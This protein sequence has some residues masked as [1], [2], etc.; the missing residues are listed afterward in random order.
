MLPRHPH[1]QHSR[2]ADPPGFAVGLQGLGFQAEDLAN[3]L[4]DV[5]KPHHAGIVLDHFAK[6]LFG[7]RHRDLLRHRL[8]GGLQAA[9]G[10]GKFAGVSRQPGR[11]KALHVARHFNPQ[12]QR[13]MFDDPQARGKIGRF[14]AADHPARQA[15]DQFR[16]E[17]VQFARGSIGACDWQ[18]PGA[19][20]KKPSA[21]RAYRLPCASFPLAWRAFRPKTANHQGSARSRRDT[22]GE[23]RAGH[24]PAGL[25]GIGW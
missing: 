25:R 4:L 6:C 13:K 9:E 2:L 15:R 21:A 22:Y 12:P 11:H 20:K 8:A 14:D 5:G 19:I 23:R 17:V 1:G 10:S 16:H 3:R 18:R 24:F 7:Q